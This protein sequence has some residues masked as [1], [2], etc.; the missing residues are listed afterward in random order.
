MPP[1]AKRYLYS[2]T[3]GIAGNGSQVIAKTYWQ[4]GENNRHTQAAGAAIADVCAC[5]WHCPQSLMARVNARSI[6]CVGRGPIFALL[7]QFCVLHSL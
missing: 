7:R 2:S 5:N 3:T 4:A 6:G 1:T